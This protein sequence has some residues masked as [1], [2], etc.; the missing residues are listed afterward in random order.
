MRRV[1]ILL[2]VAFAGIASAQPA[3]HCLAAARDGHPCAPPPGRDARALAVRAQALVQSGDRR[4]SAG[5]AANRRRCHDA[6]R[7]AALCGTFARDFSCDE[8]GFRAT[9]PA[10]LLRERPAVSHGRKFQMQR[11]ALQA[12]NGAP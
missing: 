10:E 5:Y 4:R 2:L 1:P 8:R 3:A 6:L 12:T 11:C 9:P 7:V